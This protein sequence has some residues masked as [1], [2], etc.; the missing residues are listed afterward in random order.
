MSLAVRGEPV[1]HFSARARAVF[2]VSG[3]GDTS[4]A[5]LATALAAGADLAEAVGFAIL[6]SGV[7]VG[8]VGTAVVAPDE[9]VE[10]ELAV[11]LASAEIKLASLD[12]A[13]ER[14]R[15][16]REEGLR[17]GF[18]NGCFDILHR[19]HVAYLMQ[20][21]SWCDRLIVALNS[22]ASVRRLKGESRPVN[23]LDS[24]ALVMAGLASV[25]LVTVFDAETP[26]DLITRIRPDVLI[27]GAD[28]TEDG[29]VGAR[30]VRSWGGDVRLADLVDGYST[31]AA[32]AR[33]TGK[34]D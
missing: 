10:A 6:A 19:G 13:V 33:M 1:L 14:A 16:W 24:R 31:T 17:V 15:R 9:L 26:L 11:S 29:V 34:K 5:A 28:Y 4:I 25:D 3:A 23:S 8:K 22:D 7:V 18:T 32:I 2:D 30:E 12:Q 27:K 21:R 20:A